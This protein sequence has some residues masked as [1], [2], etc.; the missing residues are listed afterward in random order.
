VVDFRKQP[1]EGLNEFQ[2]DHQ[3]FKSQVAGNNGLVCAQTFDAAG[4]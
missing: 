3:V 2:L 1:E 4:A